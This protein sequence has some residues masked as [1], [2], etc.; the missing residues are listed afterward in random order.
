[1]P[2]NEQGR[3]I[4][5]VLSFLATI[6]LVGVGVL[7]CIAFAIAKR[8]SRARLAAT[9]TVGVLAVYV[10]ALL[11]VGAASDE[12]VLGPGEPKVF[13]ELD[14]HLSYTVP[15]VRLVSTIGDAR[16]RG[17]YYLVTVRTYFDERTTA[18]WRGDGKLW[19]NPR[20]L[21]LVDSVGHAWEPDAIAQRALMASDAAGT[22]IETPLRPG[23]SY[24]TTFAFDV[25]ADVEAPRL[26]V[27]E[28]GPVTRL[29]IGHENSLLHRKTVFAL[30]RG[31][32]TGR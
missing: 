26:E 13:C 7:A 23:E 8:P 14:C 32:A 21:R 10:V 17:T 2:L 30:G 22:P 15:R 16:A 1:M 5:Q 28:D 31:F 4:L 24:E 11:G 19:P 25:P 27:F 3:A 6:G 9:L 20:G 18:P 29:L 12:R